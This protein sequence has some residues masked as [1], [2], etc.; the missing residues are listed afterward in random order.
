MRYRSQLSAATIIALLLLVIGTGNVLMGYKKGVYFE[1]AAQALAQKREETGITDPLLLERIESKRSFY[2]I[3][4]Q[5][6]IGML[7]CA[8]LLL[9]F[10]VVRRRRP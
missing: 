10:D 6:G 1:E 4:S 9:G 5:G 2:R 7:C 3:V 8:A